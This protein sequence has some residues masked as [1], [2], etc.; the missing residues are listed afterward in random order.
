MIVFGEKKR[1]VSYKRRPAAYG[2]IFNES[3]DKLAV[4]HTSDLKYFLPGGGI[5]ENENDQDCLKREMIEE[6]GITVKV[7]ACV[8]HA[9]RYFYSTSEFVYYLSEG[10]FYLCEVGEKVAEPS[11]EDHNLAW[12]SPDEAIAKLFHEHQAW[13]VKEATESVVG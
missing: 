13:A 7:G 12:L 11:E 3:K 6:L 9:E 4:L 10:H 8:G 5:E 2:I 1:G